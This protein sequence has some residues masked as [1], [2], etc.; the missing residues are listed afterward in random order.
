MGEVIHSSDA[1]DHSEGTSESRSLED[2][3]EESRIAPA[4]PSH[5]VVPPPVVVK[6]VVV[7]PPKPPV[8]PPVV[9]KPPVVRPPFVLPGSFTNVSAPKGKSTAKLADL[10]A[11]LKQK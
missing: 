9:V 5:V 1:T 4:Q 10:E 8:V 3:V 2:L 7:A 11:A 6:T